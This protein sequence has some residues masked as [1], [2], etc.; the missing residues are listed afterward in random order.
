[1][2]KGSDCA[3]LA[4]IPSREVLLAQLLGVLKAPVQKV[5]STLN[6]IMGKFVNALDQVRTQK[7]SEQPA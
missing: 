3:R 6:G 2:L 4:D 1:V 5:A 7:E